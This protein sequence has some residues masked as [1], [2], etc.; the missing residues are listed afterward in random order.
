MDHGT[1]DPLYNPIGSPDGQSLVAGLGSQGE[2]L[3][4]LSLPPKQRIQPLPRPGGQE[5]FSAVSWSPDG[6]TSPE[7]SSRRRRSEI[8]G[9]VV[10]SFAD[11]SYER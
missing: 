7:A 4:R 10:Y 5:L 8:P 11:G 6:G 1:S 2:A 3:I 9:V